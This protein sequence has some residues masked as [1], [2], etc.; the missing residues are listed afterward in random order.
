MSTPE[1]DALYTLALRWSEKRAVNGWE[2]SAP[3][4]KPMD[5]Q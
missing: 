3:T 4:G 2:E 5:F 1:T